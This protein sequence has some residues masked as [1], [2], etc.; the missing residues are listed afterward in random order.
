V[1]RELSA[2]G[3]DVKQVPPA[4]AKP[5]RQGHKN[6][7]RDAHAVAEAVQRPVAPAVSATVKT[8]EGVGTDHARVAAEVTNENVREYCD[9][10]FAGSDRIPACVQDNAG[11]LGKMQEASA[12]W[13]A[14]VVRPSSGGEY[15]LLNIGRDLF[16]P[17]LT[18][19]D[20]ATGKLEC[21]AQ[22]CNS[23]AATAQ[24]KMLCQQA[25]A[26]RTVRR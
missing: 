13:A 20:L 10:W 21:D 12:N 7:F 17:V 2:L 11:E 24:V 23:G 3:H 6:D 15:K 9:N 26:G 22:V 8:I 19:T 4:Y 25:L 1:A 5:F 16:G 14:L 18:W